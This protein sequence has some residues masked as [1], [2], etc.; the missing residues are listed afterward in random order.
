MGLLKPTQRNGERWLESSFN[1]VDGP[2]PIFH[3][4]DHRNEEMDAIARHLRHLVEVEA[5]SPKDICLLYNGGAKKELESTLAARLSEFG[6]ELSFQKNRAFERKAN[7]MIATSPHSFK[8][9]ESEVVVIPSVDHFVASEGKIVANALYVAMTRARSLLAIY[10][11]RSGSE[12]SRKVSQTISD[13]IHTQ[14]TI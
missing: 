14:R 5:I 12:A 2:K 8:G 7:T 6:V 13:C 3:Q 11:I 1:Q 4:F 9:Y 10:G